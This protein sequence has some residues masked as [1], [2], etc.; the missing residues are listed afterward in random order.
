V[1][2]TSWSDDHKKAVVRVESLTE[3]PAFALVDLTAKTAA[4][5]GPEYSG[6][7]PDDIAPIKPVVYKAKDGLEITGYLTLPRGKAAKNLPLVVL[8]HGGPAARDSLHFDWWSQALAAQ[9]Y[10]VLQPNFRGSDGVTESLL[11]AGYGEFGRKMQTDLSDGVRDLAAQGV[12]D[13]K[14]VCIVGA[15][16]GGYAALAG[17][18]LDTGVYRCAIS[19]AG[20]ADLPKMLRAERK[21][22]VAALRYWK[23]FM[24]VD[25]PDDPELIEI[26]PAHHAEKDDIPLLL[27]HGK[28]DTVVPYEQS[29][30][31]AAALKKA[32]KPFDFV[33]LESEDHWLSRGDTRQKMLKAVVDFLKKNNPPG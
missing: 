1:Q 32:G 9:G 22:S 21:D 25:G 28:D 33:T 17:A 16:Y 14:R 30:F 18:T 2:L 15:S 26:S 27:I 24:G 5:I 12:I 29:Q 23:N 7:G 13:P 3:G 31:M 11:K 4:W 20:P 8:P 6:I 10:A 19:V